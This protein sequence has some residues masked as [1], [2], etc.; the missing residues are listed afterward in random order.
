M[1]SLW[2]TCSMKMIIPYHS[3]TSSGSRATVLLSGQ[4]TI[5]VMNPLKS[6]LD[7]TTSKNP[8]LQNPRKKVTKPTYPR[9]AHVNPSAPMSSITLINNNIT[10]LHRNNQPNRHRDPLRMFRDSMRIFRQ[11]VG[12]ELTDQ[13]GEGGFGTDGELSNQFI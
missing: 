6:A 9:R 2:L 10:D 1:R 12:D 5:A 13:E 4:L 8:S 3:S 7:K 11:C